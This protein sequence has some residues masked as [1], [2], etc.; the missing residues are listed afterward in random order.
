MT[1]APDGSNFDY[2]IFLHNTGS[3]T[4]DVLWYSWIPGGD[5]MTVMPTNIVAPTG[6]TGSVQGGGAGDG[7]SVQY[8]TSSSPLGG[9]STLSGFKF[10]SSETPAELTANSP[11]FGGI[12]QTG[13]SYVYQGAAQNSNFGVLVINPVPEPITLCALA[14]ALMLMRRRRR[15]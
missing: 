3:N 14:P 1:Y 15:A 8:V 11:I 9:G 6:W 5:F 12:Y 7:Y 4:I 2:N 13:I 10:T